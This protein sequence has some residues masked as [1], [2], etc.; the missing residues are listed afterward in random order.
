MVEEKN[1]GLT[2]V[3]K[4]ASV[5]IGGDHNSQGP[6]K[7]KLWL[8]NVANQSHLFKFSVKQKATKMPPLHVLMQMVL[9]YLITWWYFCV[10]GRV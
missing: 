4:P 1:V 5:N 3:V 6:A 10:L 2:A 9:D 7:Q 8:C